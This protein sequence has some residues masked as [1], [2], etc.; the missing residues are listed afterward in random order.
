MIINNESSLFITKNV[1]S[2]DSEIFWSQSLS[3]TFSWGQNY[4]AFVILSGTQINFICPDVKLFTKLIYFKDLNQYALC[5]VVQA[6]QYV[7]TQNFRLCL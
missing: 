4:Y 2:N 7:Y 1:T 3:W 5:K 6:T